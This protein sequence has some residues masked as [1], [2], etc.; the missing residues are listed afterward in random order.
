M[1][2]R[3]FLGWVERSSAIAV[4]VIFSAVTASAQQTGTVRSDTAKISQKT[5]ATTSD[6]KGK[7]N[8]NSGGA[9]A[10]TAAKINGSGNSASPIKEV[11]SAHPDMSKS[12][13]AKPNIVRPGGSAAPKGKGIPGGAPKPAG[14]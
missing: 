10:A 4:L 14:K 7:G 1:E 3:T 12:N 2:T 11:K 8:D 5:S 6:N 9:S 13:G